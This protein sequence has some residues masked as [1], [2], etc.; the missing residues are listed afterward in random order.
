MSL[1]PVNELRA[2]FSTCG[3]PSEATHPIEASLSQ[4]P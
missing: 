4:C 3:G 1:R 2:C